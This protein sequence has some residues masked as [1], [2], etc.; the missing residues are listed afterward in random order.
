[1]KANKKNEVILLVS[2]IKNDLQFCNNDVF[3]NTFLYVVVKTTKWP[4]I[5]TL[6]ELGDIH[7]FLLKIIFHCNPRVLGLIPTNKDRIQS[8]GRSQMKGM[9][10]LHFIF[11]KSKIPIFFQIM[12]IL[13]S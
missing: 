5:D 4:C 2:S 10:I 8:T 3:A 1:M 12:S 13:I 7:Q 6:G 9:V 11:T